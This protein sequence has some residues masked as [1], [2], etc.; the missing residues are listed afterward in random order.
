[1]GRRS[2][3][4][5]DAAVRHLFRH[6]DNV[7]AVR[8]NPLVARFFPLVPDGERITPDRRWATMVRINDAILEAANRCYDDDIAENRAESGKRQRVIFRGSLEKKQPMVVAANLGISLRQYYRERSALYQRIA[9]LIQVGDIQQSCAAIEVRSP[10]RFQ[11]ERAA[12]LADACDYDCALRG[13]DEVAQAGPGPDIKIESLCK[14]AEIELERGAY[15]AARKLLAQANSLV[16]DHATELLATAASASKLQVNLLETKLAW[17]TADLRTAASS[18]AQGTDAALAIHRAGGK[19]VKD[20]CVDVV[21]EGAARAR[22]FGDFTTARA[23]LATADAISAGGTAI[24]VQQR[25]DLVMENALF[26][27][28]ATR[29]L[30]PFVIAKAFDEVRKGLDFARTCGS[31][32]RVLQGE[33]ILAQASI[34]GLSNNDTLDEGR[35]LLS[36]ARTLRNPRL[37]AI[38]ALSVGDMLVQSS[39]YRAIADCLNGIEAHLPKNSFEW[40]YLMHQLGICS[41]RARNWR[42][43]AAYEEGALQAA[44]VIGSDRMRSAALRGLALAACGLN[45]MADASDYIIAAVPIAERHGSARSLAHTLRAAFRITSKQSYARRLTE[46]SGCVAAG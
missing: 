38:T 43:A 37:F 17:E 10:S 39:R 46:V 16:C 11:M 40:A 27:I 31:L 26:S 20:L 45:R 9:Q 23:Y 36:M 19:R 15:E 18:L 4:S 13:Y 25:A 34:F 14:S 42:V 8:K 44:Q 33:L 7:D 24:S 29:G 1:M 2:D 21:I 32:K 28:I 12:R 5:F 3:T 30:H 22:L 41:I 35:R 6:L